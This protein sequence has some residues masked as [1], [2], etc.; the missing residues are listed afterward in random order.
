MLEQLAGPV[1]PINT[2]WK[3]AR[4]FTDSASLLRSRRER[5]RR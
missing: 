2:N 1:Q 5:P 3:C 4:V